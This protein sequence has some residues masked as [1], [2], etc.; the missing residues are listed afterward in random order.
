M[1]FF[2]SV[3]VPKKRE[4]VEKTND[5]PREKKKGGKEE[6]KRWGS[7]HKEKW[8]ELRRGERRRSNVESR[9]KRGGKTISQPF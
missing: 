5:Q 4:V 6:G 2:N 1:T 9:N 7:T 8:K 3:H